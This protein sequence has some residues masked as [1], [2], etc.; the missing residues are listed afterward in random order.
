MTAFSSFTKSVSRHEFPLRE[1]IINSYI[2]LNVYFSLN[3][4]PC[5][6]QHYKDVNPSLSKSHHISAAVILGTFNRV[7][8][9][10]GPMEKKFSSLSNLCLGSLSEYTSFVIST[11]FLLQDLTTA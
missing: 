6:D 1:L 9:S 3:Y 8:S 7:H 2:T 11:Q 10:W 5:V 4:I